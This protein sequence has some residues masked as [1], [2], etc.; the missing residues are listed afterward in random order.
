MAHMYR[1]SICATTL[2]AGGLSA[3]ACG[4][5]PPDQPV[6]AIPGG[7]ASAAASPATPASP[8]PAGDRAGGV[9]PNQV[10][11]DLAELDVEDQTGSGASVVIEQARLGMGPG[12]VVITPATGNVP[13]G[14]GAIPANGATN[15]T[16]GLNSPVTSS[17]ELRV[18]LYADSDGDGAFD[19]ARD[20]LVVD[21]EGEPEDDDT[22]YWIR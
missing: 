19:P 1:R 11:D 5:D 9:Q 14:V 20:A 18:V 10:R 12:L 21:D 3:A 4:S 2:L 17:G 8:Q 6:G 15:L 13:I 16:V 22:D 7:E